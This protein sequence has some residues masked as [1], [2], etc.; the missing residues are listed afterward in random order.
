MSSHPT[1][2]ERLPAIYR[3]RDA[4]PGSAGQFEAYVGLIDEVFAALDDHIEAFYHDHFIETCAD[5]TV[6][7]IGDLL[8]VSHLKGDAWTLRADVARSV[9]LRRRKGTLGAIE[10]LAFNLTGWAAHAVEMRERMVWN[11]HLNHPRP[12]RGGLP[13]FTGPR[14]IA[15]PV[16]HGTVTLRDPGVLT[17]LGGAFDQFAR[18]ADVKPAGSSWAN[19]NLPNLAVFLWRLK[20]YQIPVSAPV[21]VA[22]TTVA[23]AAPD[24]AAFA[25]QYLVHPLGRPQQLFNLHRFDPERDPPRLAVPDRTPGPMPAARLDDGP[26]TGNA[27]EYISAETYAGSRPDDSGAGAVGLVIHLPDVPFAGTAWTTRGANLCAWEGGLSPPLRRR[28]IVIDPVRGRLLLGI[29]DDVVEGEAL[30]R[31]LRISATTAAPGP[32]GAHPVD[33]PETP[34]FWLGEAVV[35]R[36]VSAHPGGL[37]LEA[38]LANLSDPGPPVIVEIADSMVHPLDLGAVAGIF[39]ENGEPAIRLARPLW[40]RA[41][42][43]QRPIIALRQPL[44]LRPAAVAGPGAEALRDRLDVHLEGLFLT[45]RGAPVAG[46]PIIAQAAVNRLVLDGVTLDPA[47]HV[48]PD[49]IRQPMQAALGLANDYGFADAGEAAVF[50]E[51][52]AIVLSRSIT[53]PI[54]VGDSFTLDVTDS[55]VDGGDGVGAGPTGFAIA[56]PANPGAAW[57][58]ALTVSGATF[59]GWVRV[60]AA[61]GT[62]GIWVHPLE[63]RDH[64]S[65]CISHSYFAAAGN[66]LPQ[67]N[68]AIFGGSAPL[69]FTSEVFGTPGYGQLA[70]GRADRRLHED[71][72]N[73]DQMG[74]FGYQLETH[75]WKNLSI[76]LREF[77]PVGVRPILA[78]VT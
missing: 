30:R 39:F 67:H 46:R 10:Q 42:S 55:I 20:D 15:E 31:G 22:T 63:V 11:Q 73:A 9:A 18:V 44:R 38:A 52:P 37:S 4:D 12:D 53:G 17:L 78:T 61:T 76:R 21:H 36:R 29:A 69:A 58:P 35:S 33:R 34:E 54:A 16:R 59:F 48:A 25:A 28:E 23:A 3:E 70:R 56:A 5:W 71:G 47:G 1:L 66:R 64:Q 60:K 6:P 26:P 57:G 72:P 62:G 45:L 41:L 74:A 7:Y 8:G 2:F 50:A 51:R 14:H 68:A 24:E 49:G 13:P 43:G 27:S 32:T 77:T 75:R 40:I 65:G 19:P